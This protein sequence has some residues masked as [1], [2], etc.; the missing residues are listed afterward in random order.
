MKTNRNDDSVCLH[1]PSVG[2]CR[3]GVVAIV[4]SLSSNGSAV[5]VA[6]E[7]E[8][9]QAWTGE[10]RDFQQDD[11]QQQRQRRSAY[12]IMLAISDSGIM[13]KKKQQKMSQCHLR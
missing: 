7:R 3:P 11:Q 6:T 9:A 2:E 4:E 10:W 12:A 5:K 13:K 8:R 1:L